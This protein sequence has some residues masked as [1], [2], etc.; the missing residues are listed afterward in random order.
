MTVYIVI[1]CSATGN[2]FAPMVFDSLDRAAA[3]IFTNC[4]DATMNLAKSKYPY[5][6]YISS[7]NTYHVHAK[8][9]NAC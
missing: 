5:Y 4:P 6:R 2:T 7:S 8:E 3:W 1:D 9:V